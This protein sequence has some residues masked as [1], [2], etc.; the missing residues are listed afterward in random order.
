MTSVIRSQ[1]S[2]ADG[3]SLFLV[4]KLLGHANARTTERYAHL[5]GDPLQDAAAAIGKKLMPAKEP[6]TDE[7]EDK[8]NRR[9]FPS[10]GRGMSSATGYGGR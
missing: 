4:G 10:C 1:V 8:R 3:A 7:K 9:G 5:S 2:V 6:A